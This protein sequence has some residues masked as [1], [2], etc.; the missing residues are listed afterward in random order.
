MPRRSDVVR[1]AASLML[2][3]AIALSA[4][5]MFLALSRATYRLGVPF[6]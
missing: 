2:I 4:V 3:L 5:A 6:E 1:K